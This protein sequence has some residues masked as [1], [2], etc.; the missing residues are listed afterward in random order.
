MK[1]NAAIALT[2][3]ALVLA[4]CGTTELQKKAMQDSRTLFQCQQE[5]PATW[6]DDCNDEQ[7]VYNAD[8]DN[9]MA[10]SAD[11]KQAAIDVGLMLLEIAFDVAADMPNQPGGGHHSGHQSA[12]YSASHQTIHHPSHQ[13]TVHRTPSQPTIHRTPSQPTVHHPSSQPTVHR[14]PSHPAHPSAAPAN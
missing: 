6:R 3:I 10:D 13:P 8:Q 11:R 2:M 12:H 4:G 7:Q 14:T 9:A 5:H 1:R